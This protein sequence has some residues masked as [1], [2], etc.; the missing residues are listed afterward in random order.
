MSM[1]MQTRSVLVNF[2]SKMAVVTTDAHDQFPS[3]MNSGVVHAP[4]YTDW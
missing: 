3:L 4:N 2:E 1:S